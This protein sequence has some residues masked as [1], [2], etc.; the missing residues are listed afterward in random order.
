MST[1]IITL[2][3]NTTKEIPSHSTAMTL[4]ESI[5]RRLAKEAIAAKVNGKVVDLMSE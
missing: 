1:I 2:K 4:A 3:D 5:S